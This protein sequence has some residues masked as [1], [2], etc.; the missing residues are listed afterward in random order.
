MILA[1]ALFAGTVSFS[2]TPSGAGLAAA[3]VA[4]PGVVPEALFDA[5][6]ALKQGV[7]WSGANVKAHSAIFDKIN[8]GRS[9]VISCGGP[10]VAICQDAGLSLDGILQMLVQ[11][12]C[13]LRPTCRAE[14]EESWA[15]TGHT[16]EDT[17]LATALPEDLDIGNFIRKVPLLAV[18]NRLDM[19]EMDASGKTYTNAELRFIYG[20]LLQ[21]MTVSVEFV[22]APMSTG[23]FQATAQQWFQHS[24]D[25]ALFQK[26]AADF[27][28]SQIA[29][30]SQLR[31][32]V[33]RK[34]TNGFWQVAQWQ[35]TLADGKLT[36]EPALLDD[37]LSNSVNGRIGVDNGKKQKESWQKYIAL[38][39]APSADKIPHS[40]GEEKRVQYM[41]A[42]PC[43]GIPMPKEAASKE[44]AELKR[45]T[46]GMRQ[47]S[48]CHRIETGTDFQHVGNRGELSAYLRAANGSVEPKL[49]EVLECSQKWDAAACAKFPLSRSY[50]RTMHG[51]EEISRKDESRRFSDFV[52]RKVFLTTVLLQSVGFPGGADLPYRQT[53][54]RSG[55]SMIGSKL[56]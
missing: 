14:L 49:A 39:D 30:A 51:D 15:S 25:E 13:P 6:R 16:Q 21:K 1:L 36:L 7:I 34:L 48:G 18:V 33:N 53:L 2:Q 56:N 55:S 45:Q 42:A 4:T 46:I 11:A 27:V 50:Y 40:E 9:L 52:L 19:A 47:C 23:V 35:L 24:T 17:H 8:S 38:F 26:S 3:T 44:N 28:K 20:L 32:R 12:K 10:G 54:D 22:L 43:P 41:C 37:E 31:V 29:S 5:G